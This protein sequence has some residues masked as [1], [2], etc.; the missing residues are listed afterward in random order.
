MKAKVNKVDVISAHAT[1][2]NLESTIE[3]R[4]ADGWCLVGS[5][6]SCPLNGG[7]T[8]YIVSWEREFEVE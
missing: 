3:R 2:D 4:N 8:Y 7:N 1:I 6:T 5:V